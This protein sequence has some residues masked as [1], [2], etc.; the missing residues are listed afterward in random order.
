MELRLVTLLM[1]CV[2]GA[3][4]LRWIGPDSASSAFAWTG[5]FL[6]LFAWFFWDQTQFNRL[7]NWL[8]AIELE[9]DP[10]SYGLWG[11]LSAR[12]RRVLRNRDQVIDDERRRLQEFLAALQASPNGVMLLNAQDRIEWCNQTAA[13]HF[14]LDVER[15][16]Q[17]AIGNLVREPGFAAYLARRNFA[18]AVLMYGRRSTPGKPVRLSVQLHPYG[19]GR[20][21]LLST[22]VTALEQAESMRREFVANVSH[23]IRTPLTVLSG[24]VETLQDLELEPAERRSYVALMGQQTER[25]QTLVAD[26]L[27]LSRLE[28]SPAPAA[29]EWTSTTELMQQLEQDA[30]ALSH[31]MGADTPQS[32]I[33]RCDFDGALAGS[34]SEIRSAMGNLVSNAVRYT[35]AGG[36]I[37]VLMQAAEDG[38]LRFMVKDTGSGIAPEHLGRLTERFYRVDRSRSRESGGT[39]LGLAIVKH[40]AQRHGA[41]LDIAS[42]LGKGSAFTLT[43]P[44]QRVR[45]GESAGQR[46]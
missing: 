34:N 45:A 10:P 11:E 38:G 15:D 41:R 26:L 4:V 20:A 25:M 39:G 28:G 7:Q 35:P 18:Q 43:F 16:M 14:G 5:A 13:S 46:R 40:V 44:P 21:L 42:T 12:I 8:S 32:L 2:L 6:G 30:W 17:Q 9:R 19:Q 22:D 23:E 27:M 33:F 24:F 1:S 29:S 3:L 36:R 37:D 31:V